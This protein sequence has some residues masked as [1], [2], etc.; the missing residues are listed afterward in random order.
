MNLS[1]YTLVCDYHIGEEEFQQALDAVEKAK[2]AEEKAREDVDKN[3]SGEIEDA[4]KKDADD[5]AEVDDKN[6]VFNVL[7]ILPNL[8]DAIAKSSSFGVSSE[9]CLSSASFFILFNDK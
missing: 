1:G 4:T 6:A 9:S 8:F 2:E 3:L 5:E 7:P